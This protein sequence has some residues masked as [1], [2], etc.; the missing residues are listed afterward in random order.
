MFASDKISATQIFI[1]LPENKKKSSSVVEYI[2]KINEIFLA[3]AKPQ[4]SVV[5]VV[6]IVSSD[7]RASSD[8]CEQHSKNSLQLNSV[9]FFRLHLRRAKAK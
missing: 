3:L 4:P 7:K 9:C 8:D 1:A 5:R 6:K 2:V